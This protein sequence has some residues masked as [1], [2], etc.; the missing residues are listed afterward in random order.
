MT[1]FALLAQ[2]TRPRRS[3]SLFLFCPVSPPSVRSACRVV[4]PAVPS[5]RPAGA[6]VRPLRLGPGPLLGRFP[7]PLVLP[8]LSASLAR[9]S[10]PVSLSQDLKVSKWGEKDSSTKAGRR[11]QTAE[12]RRAGSRGNAEAS[13]GQERG[14]ARSREGA[15]RPGGRAAGRRPTRGE[16]TER[17][18]GEEKRRREA[19][20]SEAGG[21]YETPVYRILF[22]QSPMEKHRRVEAPLQRPLP[23]APRPHR[24]P[25]SWTS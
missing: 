1:L 7:F 20:E 4:S 21:N 22:C 3:P 2:K 18:D 16:R 11:P 17:T 9:F 10:R 15:S 14:R 6:A 25:L 12:E 13:G 23:T 19:G 8:L 5:V 24:G